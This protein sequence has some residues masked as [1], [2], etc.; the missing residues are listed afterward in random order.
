MRTTKKGRP[1]ADQGY[2]TSDMPPDRVESR[3]PGKLASGKASKPSRV[4][5]RKGARSMGKTR[6]RGAR[7]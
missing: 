7:S 6:P 5:S 4:E 2:A 1:R 3:R